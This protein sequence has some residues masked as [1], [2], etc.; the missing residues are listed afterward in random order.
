MATPISTIPDLVALLSSLL[1]LASCVSGNAQPVHLETFCNNDSNYTLD[2]KFYGNL[3]V[4][5]IR[6]LYNYGGISGFYNATEGDYPNKV[7]GLFLCRGDVDPRTCQNCIDLAGRAILESCTGRKRAIIWYDQCLVRYSDESFFHV[8]EAT[9]AFY[10]VERPGNITYGLNPDECHRAMSEVFRNLSTTAVYTPSKHMYETGRV[11]ISGRVELYGLVQCTPDLLA[12]DCVK[13]LQGAV[14]E[15][16]RPRDKQVWGQGARVLTP[17]CNIRY[18]I[19]P[20]VAEGGT[21]ANRTGGTDGGKRRK[22]MWITLSTSALASMLVISCLYFIWR[23]KNIV[24]CNENNQDLQLSNIGLGRLMGVGYLKDHLQKGNEVKSENFPMIQLDNIHIATQ[25]FSHENK[26]GE[27]GFGS[28]YKGTLVDGKEIAVK[29]L[30]RNSGQGL[31]EFKNEVDLIARLQHKNLVKLLGCCL[32]ANELLLI[33]EYM[34]NKS[35]DLFLFDST[36][37]TQLDWKKC[38]N[39]ING[40]ARGLLYLH[41]DS[42]LKVIHRDLKASNVLLD[43]EMNPKISDFGM[44]R[45]FGG[46]QNEANTNRVVGT[47]GYMAPEYAID[48]LF[49]V[50]SDVFSFGV[51]ILEIISGKKN[52]GF[53]ISEHGQSLLTFAWKLWCEGRG[54]DLMNSLLVDSCVADEVLKC[55]HI[56]LLC[57]QEDPIDRPT[58]SSVVVMLASDTLTLPQPTQPAFGRVVMR[59]IL[60]SPTNNVCSA[61]VVTISNVLPR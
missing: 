50:K 44:A 3:N 29:R 18:E 24:E 1:L 53:H 12:S 61:N 2:S 32:E 6:S 10:L 4:L 48:G 54:L 39:I 49:S 36:K 17:S 57:V 13:C 52:S 25:Y 34:P 9:P 7:Y 60:S 45:I 58:I 5:L 16:P 35:L 28:V 26:L 47:Y 46:N 38:L 20:F 33:Y 51:I 11:N 21:S 19:Y 59:S 56:G 30:S 41:E 55:I 14:S 37:G 23:K 42:R 27:G 22:A 40:I 8:M 43:H 31:Q 15:L